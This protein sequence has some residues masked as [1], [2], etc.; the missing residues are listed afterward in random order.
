MEKMQVTW[1]GVQ[2]WGL[3]TWFSTIASYK[4]LQAAIIMPQIFLAAKTK[5]KTQSY[6]HNLN[7][8]KRRNVNFKISKNLLV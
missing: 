6:R 8:S 4:L 3:Y 7:V 1:K 2:R 5:Q